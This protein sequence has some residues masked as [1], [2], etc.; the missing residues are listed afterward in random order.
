MD[1][2]LHIY[3]GNPGLWNTVMALLIFGGLG[4]IAFWRDTDGLYVGGPLAIGLAMLL[5][6]ALL[7]WARDNQRYIEEFGPW[8]VF[9]IIQA[10]LLLGANAWHKARRL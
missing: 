2:I 5:S 1:P 9:L 10:I 8:A 4:R 3:Y 7:I 6:V